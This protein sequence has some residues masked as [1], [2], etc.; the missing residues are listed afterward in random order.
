MHL[1]PG[2]F[3]LSLVGLLILL[4][5]TSA[6]IGAMDISVPEIFDILA[7][8]LGFSDTS[9]NPAKTSVFWSIRLPRIVLG[10]L[11]GAGL[12]ASGV[13]LQ[14]LFRNPLADP[15]LI[16]ISSGASLA[17]A[18]AIILGIHN[19]NQV[20]PMIAQFGLPL[21]TFLGAGITAIIVFQLSRF[22]GQTAIA[23]M[24]LA[25]IA[26]NALAMAGTGFM[27]YLADDAQLADIT[28]WM[29]GSLGGANWINI[30]SIA[31][32]II[33]PLL[34]MPLL[35]KALN[36]FALG[37][38]NAAYLGV[39]TSMLKIVIVLLTTLAIGAAVAVS[40]VIG[41]VGLV[42]PHLVR[43]VV[44]SDHKVLL[45]GSMLLGASLLISADLLCRTIVAPAELP[46][47]ILTAF[48]GT[49]LFLGILI[50]K[51]RKSYSLS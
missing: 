20:S 39:N 50:S 26:I 11:V 38:M 41:F 31:P 30:A 46:I 36:S 25:G 17:A 5:L 37:E 1:K 23:T 48:I 29:L 34:L 28:F 49:P 45:P 13:C 47:G 18:I 40:G 19:L 43:M 24:L 15:S 8:K 42:V 16:G 22:G 3:L 27:T 33:V 6:G 51:T 35:S 7:Y 14:G 12:S 21:V 9:P 4:I 44:G 10:I 2:I 32:F